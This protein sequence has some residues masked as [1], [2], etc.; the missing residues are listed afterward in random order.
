MQRCEVVHGWLCALQICQLNSQSR[1]R[2]GSVHCSSEFLISVFCS[3]CGVQMQR[4]VAVGCWAS[5]VYFYMRVAALV[6]A[7]RNGHRGSVSHTEVFM[8]RKERKLE[9]PSVT[10]T[11]VER[12]GLVTPGAQVLHALGHSQDR[13]RGAHGLLRH[14]LLFI[15]LVA[16]V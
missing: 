16:T 1:I 14:L 7:Q 5:V 10:V 3:L 8:P 6:T 9:R 2:D 12:S 13:Q 15:W 11:V 4:K